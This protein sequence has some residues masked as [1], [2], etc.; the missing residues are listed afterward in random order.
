[1]TTELPA[2]SHAAAAADISFALPLRILALQTGHAQIEP[3]D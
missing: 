2:R 1:M 3:H